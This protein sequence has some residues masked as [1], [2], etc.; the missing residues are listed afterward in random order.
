[1]RA[2][3]IVLLEPV[4]DD[5]LGLLGRREPLQIENFST[6]RPFLASLGPWISRN[7]YDIPA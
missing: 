7:H 3:V 1:M 4:I 5:D 6:Q 2:G